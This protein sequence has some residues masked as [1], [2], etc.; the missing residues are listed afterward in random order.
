MN[1]NKLDSVSE[2]FLKVF[3][4]VIKYFILLGDKCSDPEYSYQ[5]YQ[6]LHVL[7][8]Y[9][10]V[11]ISTVGAMLLISKSRMTVL[12]D[13]LI[14]AQLIE[15]FP[16]KTD[17]RIIKIGLTG[18]GKELTEKHRGNLKAAVSKR[19]ENLT[20]DEMEQFLKSI[21]IIQHVMKKTEWR[22]KIL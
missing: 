13:K 12:V 11:P 17:R 16:D 4:T 18:K 8:E 10:K 20:D 5:D 9:G 2:S 3:P 14:E 22:E 19:F 1:E 15:R 21:E 6:T 7:K